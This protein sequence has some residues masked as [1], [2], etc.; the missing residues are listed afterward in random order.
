MHTCPRTAACVLRTLGRRETKRDGRG[1]ARG[2]AF[3]GTKFR[4]FDERK[5]IRGTAAAPRRACRSRF[6]TK[7]GTAGLIPGTH[8]H[9][10]P[11]PPAFRNDKARPGSSGVFIVNVARRSRDTPRSG[12]F[13]WFTDHAHARLA[14]GQ[15][16]VQD[17]LL[18]LRQTKLGELCTPRTINP[19]AA[20]IP[21]A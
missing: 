6:D 17:P 16:R 10:I 8:V 15:R 12:Y 7:T 21:R 1:R 5:A 19:R 14:D 11:A 18:N 2:G 4:D 3:R 13:I 20:Y 9:R